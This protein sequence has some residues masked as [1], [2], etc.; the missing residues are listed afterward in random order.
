MSTA[1]G[2]RIAVRVAPPPMKGGTVRDVPPGRRDV[3]RLELQSE[4]GESTP[5]SVV[6]QLLTESPTGGDGTSTRVEFRFPY[7]ISVTALSEHDVVLEI[8]G[9]IEHSSMLSALEFLVDT[10]RMVGHAPARSRV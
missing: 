7:G 8:N 3:R 9:D 2:K 6:V 1:D 10:L 5:E 4:H